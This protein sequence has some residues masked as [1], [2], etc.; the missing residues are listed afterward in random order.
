MNLPAVKSNLYL[1][2]SILNSTYIYTHTH[3]PVHQHF[4]WEIE[5]RAQ[6]LLLKS[7]FGKDEGGGGGEYHWHRRL[8]PGEIAP[9]TWFRREESTTDRPKMKK[10][11]R[12]FSRE[13]ECEVIEGKSGNELRG[14]VG[15]REWK[16]WGLF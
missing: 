10:K 6:M 5:T 9:T 15:T 8:D 16:F 14:K 7:C 12:G 1:I 2:P 13:R 3:T 11:I 4:E